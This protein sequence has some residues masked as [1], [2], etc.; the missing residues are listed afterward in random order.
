MYFNEICQIKNGRTMK[1]KLYR[2]PENNVIEDISGIIK[3]LTEKWFTQDVLY[4]TKKDLIYQDVMCLY[5]DNVLIS[6]IIFTCWDGDINITLIGTHPDYQ[7]KGYGTIL[8]KYF[9]EY[10]KENGF[11]K[12]LLLT[13][14]PEVNENYES[15]VKFYDKLGFKFTKKYTEIWQNGALQFVKELY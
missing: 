3:L 4:D 15:T 5:Q 7:N 11:F 12:V 8:F 1:V 6:F 14:P 2:R 9:C 10:I 13:V